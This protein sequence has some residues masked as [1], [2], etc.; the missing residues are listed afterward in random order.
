MGVVCGNCVG[1]VVC[2]VMDVVV[3][4]GVFEWGILCIKIY[5]ILFVLLF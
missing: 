5:L 4:I 3:L 2:F 1:G